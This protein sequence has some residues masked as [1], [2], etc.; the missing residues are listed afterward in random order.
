M[1]SETER[2]GSKEVWK[3]LT[4]AFWGSVLNCVHALPPTKGK[5]KS[6]SLITENMTFSG[7]RIFADVIKLRS[8]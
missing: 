1:A 5:F 7:N 2:A 4:V 3:R 8:L 6:Q